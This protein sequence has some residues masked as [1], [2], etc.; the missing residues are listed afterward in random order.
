MSN[1]GN[2][3]FNRELIRILKLNPW[4]YNTNYVNIR[5]KNMKCSWAEIDDELQKNRIDIKK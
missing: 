4:I 1:D 2:E 5:D 3:K